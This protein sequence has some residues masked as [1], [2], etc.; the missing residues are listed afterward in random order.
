MAQ[1][2]VEATEG[3]ERVVAGF[4]PVAEEAVGSIAVGD[5]VPAEP[6][7]IDRVV[8]AHLPHG[9]AAPLELAEVGAE[10][11]VEVQVAEI[12][13]LAG[14][15]ELFGGDRNLVD[16][17]H[18]ARPEADLEVVEVLD[19]QR[20]GELGADGGADLGTDVGP[21]VDLQAVVLA[22]AARDEELTLG[23]D[24]GG[25]VLG[26]GEHGG[27]QDDGDGDQC[28]VLHV[29]FLQTGFLPPTTTNIGYWPRNF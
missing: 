14:E 3:L 15:Q 10:G 16:D 1:I 21:G 19:V 29:V 2:V 22:D 8:L 13:G 18:D 6:E 27:E 9:V 28:Q 5:G 7:I 26:V 11:D 12:L 17:R 4:L 23:V 24:L 20:V 25:Q